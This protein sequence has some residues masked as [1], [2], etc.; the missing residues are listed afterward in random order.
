MTP[1]FNPRSPLGPATALIGGAVWLA[2]WWH[3]HQQKKGARDA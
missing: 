3:K 2:R 1:M